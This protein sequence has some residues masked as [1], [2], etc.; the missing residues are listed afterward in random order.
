MRYCMGGVLSGRRAWR[1]LVTTL[2]QPFA[3]SLSR[4]PA[5]QPQDRAAAQTI[6]TRAGQRGDKHGETNPGTSRMP[7][8][9]ESGEPPAAAESGGGTPQGTSGAREGA[10]TRLRAQA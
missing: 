10:V 2:G 7:F 4:P 6:Q 9:P 8:S 3:A 1:C 5:D